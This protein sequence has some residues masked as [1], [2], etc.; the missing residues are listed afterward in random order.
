MRMSMA[1][2]N[3][4]PAPG[5]PSRRSSSGFIALIPVA[6]LAACLLFAVVLYAGTGALY[7][8]VA[9]TLRDPAV[10][11]DAAA[12]LSDNSEVYD[13][14]GRVLLATYGSDRRSLIDT[15]EEIPAAAID[16]TTAVEDKTFW[17][18]AGFDPL[19]FVSA[20]FDTLAGSGRGGSTITQQ[21]VRNV[22]LEP[23][24]FQ[25]SV[26]Q[27][28]VKEIVQ[29]IR[30]T[31]TFPGVE[32]KRIIMRAYLN[33]NYY[34]SRAYGLRAAA[35]EYFGITDLSKLSLGQITL[36]VG[37]PQAPTKYDLRSAAVDDTNGVLRVALDAPVAQ[38]RLTVLNALKNARD[39]GLLLDGS[40]TDDAL[41]AAGQ[42]P[43]TL[44]APPL[45][46][47]KAPNYIDIVTAAAEGI[48]CPPDQPDYCPNGIDSELSSRGYKITTALDWGM[49]Q[50]SDKWAAAVLS[51]QVGK[52][53]NDPARL[54]YLK[55]LGV[56]DTA[57]LRSSYKGSIHNAA[58]GT[59]DARTG[60]MLAYTGSADYYAQ[61]TD[62][63]I[64]QIIGPLFQPQ[65]DVLS[66]YRQPGSAIK[67]VIYG[68]SLELGAVTPSTVL[69]DVPVDF[70]KGWTPAEWDFRERGPVRMREALQG[71]LNIPAIKTATRAGPDNIWRMMRDGAFRFQADTNVAGS[72]LAIGTLEIRYVDLLSAYGALANG[73][74]L[75]PR[76]YILKIENRDGSLRYEAPDPASGAKQ[77][78]KPDTAALITDIIS[79]NTD[80]KINPIWAQRRIL[81]GGKR[82]PATLKT[83]TTNDAK[84][85]TA[86]GYLAPPSNPSEPQLVTGAW[87]GNSDSTPASGLS[88]GAAG[89]IWQ[90]VLTDQSAALPIA[91]FTP[92]TLPQT[93]IDAL[94]GELPGPCTTKTI[95]E[96]FFPGTAPTT[97]CT[98][99]VTLQIDAA[100]GLIWSPGCAGP[101][102]EGSYIDFGRIETDYPSWQAANLEWADRARVGPE[103]IGGARQGVTSYFYNKDWMPNGPTWGGVIAPTASCLSSDAPRFP[104]APALVGATDTSLTV[105]WTPPS[106]PGASPISGYEYAVNDGAWSAP[107]STTTSVT[108]T[109]LTPGTTY[110]I[111]VRALNGSGG[112]APSA[113]SAFT[114]TGVA[115]S[116]STSPSPTTTPPPVP[117]ATPTPS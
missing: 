46:T 93:T 8:R 38:R 31:K 108:I 63:A 49:Q 45:T 29:A 97:S 98:T 88:L 74:V 80:P 48:L 15:F 67:P 65:F 17:T 16:A 22:L 91:N 28:K 26:Y 6:L 85:L 53:V 30:V 25:G 5:R 50:V 110:S 55:G 69:M 39:A 84:D 62:P 24:D 86:F 117:T 114:T 21:L 1:A 64:G 59:L 116:P 99:S 115:P 13:R 54:A 82:R 44:I 72:S 14:T 9:T 104:G 11:Q 42:E 66:A 106:Y 2:A 89:G 92:P 3:R 12:N 68:Y 96:Y 77:I 36:L 23:A 73:G 90:A 111:R 95:S 94:T 113:A 109:G 33:S 47:V 52:S 43:I 87:A 27:R 35:E 51:V 100:T 101:M 103:Q 71:S 102:I 20:A 40:L 60:D 70:G 7:G 75:V 58:V 37:I 112:G 81:V 34:G 105:S 57:W 107:L 79:G 18:N 61:I 10:L 41:T 76:R 78:F 56:K 83:G 4:P 19:G 32:G